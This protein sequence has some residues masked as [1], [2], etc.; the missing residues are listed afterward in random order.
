MHPN[1]DPAVLLAQ[2][3]WVR[4]LARR[5]CTDDATAD[6]L[7]QETLRLA[8]ESGPQHL[9][10]V[11][12][13]R[14]KSPA[15]LRA[16][17]RTTL[18]TLAR[19]T[20]RT[21]RR[22]AAREASTAAAQDTSAPATL[23]VVARAELHERVVHAVLALREPYRRTLLARYFDGDDVAAIAMREGTT[24]ATIRKRLE[25]AVATLRG[26]LVD[27][28]DAPARARRALAA[29]AGLPTPSPTP[30]ATSGAIALPPLIGALLM[31]RL[32]SAA[33]ALLVLAA[34]A[35]TF[36]I[37]WGQRTDP[38]VTIRTGER[39]AGAIPTADESTATIRQPVSPTDDLASTAGKPIDRP[40][41]RYGSLRIEA[42]WRD[43]GTPAASRIVSARFHHG[44]NLQ[45]QQQTDDQGIALFAALPPGRYLVQHDCF[46]L[47]DVLVH[48]AQ[49]TPLRLFASRPGSLRGRVVDQHGLGVPNAQ[50]TWS[51][52]QH[53][54]RGQTRTDAR[55]EFALLEVGTNL[56]VHAVAGERRFSTTPDS[57]YLI[58]P[59]EVREVVLVE[60]R[61]HRVQAAAAVPTDVTV[62]RDTL[63]DI[64][65]P[66]LLSLYGHV[67]SPDGRALAGAL[68]SLSV[69]D[70][71]RP[72]D[73]TIAQSVSLGDGSFTFDD[74]SPG[75]FVVL[76]DH[77]G[78]APHEHAV[79]LTTETSA[80]DIT[81]TAGP[82]IHGLLLDSRAAPLAGWIVAARATG[83]SR[84]TFTRPDGTFDLAVAASTEHRLT[85]RDPA[86]PHGSRLDRL[87]R[88]RVVPSPDQQR[89]VVPDS[90]AP[91]AWIHGSLTDASTGRP[92]PSYSVVAVCDEFGGTPNAP[93]DVRTGRFQ[94]GPLPPGTWTLWLTD[95]RQRAP[96]LEPG[97]FEL[98]AHQ[99]LEVPALEIPAHGELEVRVELPDGCAL[100]PEHLDVRLHDEAGAY[101]ANTQRRRDAPLSFDPYA[102]VPAGVIR[103]VCFGPGLHLVDRRVTIEPGQHNTV[104]LRPRPG[105][106][107]WIRVQLPEPASRDFSIQHRI[108]DRSDG[109]LVSDSERFVAKDGTFELHLA[110]G[111]YEL[112]LRH[113][114]GARGQF[115][116]EAGAG[117]PDHRIE[118]RLQ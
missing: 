90:T 91:T 47:R 92:P 112:T 113:E 75:K 64:P 15:R 97:P 84:E 98:T 73:A 63:V 52:M 45:H 26:Q 66:P 101:Y 117:T 41:P 78:F 107:T 59:G 7:S 8:L 10:P 57:L 39:I 69:Q 2:T 27:R 3:G 6:D 71:N 65:C 44:G 46:G 14:C 79:E 49:E 1:A 102:A 58:L 5:L 11:P 110:P 32:A 28:A 95:G 30:A 72:N 70:A 51:D 81:L 18:H 106:T 24:P 109:T 68:V 116:I 37:D 48:P 43:D 76:T 82:T 33:L 25:R 86:E 20:P 108:V 36:W 74:L 22:R 21:D 4:A 103:V 77:P 55:G 50:V 104:T 9:Q 99:H 105:L 35:L 83:P 29:L 12:G 89:F 54:P 60:H 53:H 114:S 40:D 23:D 34:T 13:T 61:A 16:W 85:A 67:R 62:D 80:V 94:V 100:R 42:V 118:L 93:V 19:Q 56:H 31:K 115:T 88:E 111:S 96:Y 17:L 87:R 38:A